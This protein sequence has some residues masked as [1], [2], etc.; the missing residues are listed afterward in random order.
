MEPAIGKR[1]MV[2][3]GYYE[4]QPETRHYIR[5]V[6]D[7]G[8]ISY[9]PLC[10]QLE[11]EFAA[12]HDC[13]HAVLSASGT[14][15]LRAALHAMKIL[16]KWHD[17]D[18]VIIPATTFVATANIVLQIGMVPVFVD[19]EDTTYCINP[20]LIE[21]AITDK[22]RAI[23]P[24]NLL[25]QPADLSAV[26]E[27]AN[28]RNLMVVEDSCEAMFVR[29][30]G[31]PVGSWG[32]IGCFSFY[33][34]HLITAG[35]GGVATTNDDIYA[36]LMRS[37]LNHGR[38]TIYTSIDDD[39]GLKDD[40][41]FNVMQKR[42]NFLYPGYS[43]RMTELQAALALPQLLHSEQMLQKRRKVAAELTRR[44]TK[45]GEYLKLPV[46]GN[47]NE[48]SWMM[49]GLKTRLWGASMLRFD[50]ESNGIETR[51]L[52]PLIDQPIYQE[53]VSGKS[54]PV[55]ENLLTHGFYIGS[56]QGMTE[57]DCEYVERAFEEAITKSYNI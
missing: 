53:L 25:G 43:S 24:V 15:S 14:D 38:D 19:V 6:L 52:L 4:T 49:Y 21:D 56:H 48:H 47:G 51:D 37:L 20:A 41:L 50:L 35:V 7:S 8:R 55:A 31:R 11:E 45:F 9:G 22:T 32:Q 18:E 28:R 42:F 39:D 16:H 17:G 34:A 40:R 2:E 36:D 12:A 3:V 33:M 54:Y 46:V 23:I 57:Q 29:H 1:K 5:Q 27:I 26:T 44:L 10:R 13:K 30:N